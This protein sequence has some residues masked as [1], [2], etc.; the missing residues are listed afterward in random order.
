MKAPTN[1]F[2]YLWNELPRSER[3]RLMPMMIESQILHI[4]Q[5]KSK[6]IRAHKAHM[7]GLN[8]QISNLEKLL[9]KK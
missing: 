9:P 8:E 1:N 5:C 6:A 4:W 7:D 2:S 3:E